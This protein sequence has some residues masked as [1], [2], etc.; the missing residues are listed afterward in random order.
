MPA[1]LFVDKIEENQI[2]GWTT[3][4]TRI[5]HNLSVVK[6]TIEGVLSQ[7]PAGVLLP[8]AIYHVGRY[9]VIFQTDR[10]MQNARMAFIDYQIDLQSNF[11]HFADFLTPKTVGG[12][13]K[14]QEI[15]KQKPQTELDLFILSEDPLFF[16][17]GSHN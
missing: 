6:Q 17:T 16:Q 7:V 4:L 9:V 11:D 2:G 3:N 10:S 12:F 1:R 14:I 8:T 15:I 5:K 13:H